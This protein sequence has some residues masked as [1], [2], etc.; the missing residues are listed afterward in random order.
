MTGNKHPTIG[1]GNNIP[2]MQ[3]FTGISRNSQSK[4]YKLS[5]TECALNFKNNALWD[6]QKHAL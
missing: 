4:S 1:H 5:L 3:F 2:E 6:T